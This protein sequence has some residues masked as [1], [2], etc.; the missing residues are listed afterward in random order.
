VPTVLRS[1]T[2]S[3][4]SVAL[5]FAYRDAHQVKLT[6]GNSSIMREVQTMRGLSQAA[7]KQ[8]RKTL[9]V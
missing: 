3:R 1:T 5:I 7:A 2:T 4:E 8:F 9:K 6:V